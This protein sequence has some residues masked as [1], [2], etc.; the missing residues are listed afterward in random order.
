MEFIKNYSNFT[1]ITEKLTAGEF[2]I[3]DGLLNDVSDYLADTLD[4]KEWVGMDNEQKT[5]LSIMQ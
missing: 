5:M 3:V 2:N 4:H 1:P